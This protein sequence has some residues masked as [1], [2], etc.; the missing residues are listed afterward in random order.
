[1]NPWEDFWSTAIVV[2]LSVMIAANAFKQGRA[3]YRDHFYLT[4]GNFVIS[5]LAYI[6][7]T[8]SGWPTL[9]EVGY[10]GLLAIGAYFLTLGVW[11]VFGTPKKVE[12]FRCQYVDWPKET[13]EPRTPFDKRE[14]DDF[15]KLHRQGV[16]KRRETVTG[17][18]GEESA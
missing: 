11:E 17:S 6:A 16:R 15:R 13:D 14:L 10:F 8:D 3:A 1:M 2:G 4:A 7:N 9:I 18:D 12:C 5:V